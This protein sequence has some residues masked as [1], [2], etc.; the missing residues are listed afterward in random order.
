[1][2]GSQ[3]GDCPSIVIDDDRAGHHNPSAKST[4]R[5]DRDNPAEPRNRRNARRCG[6]ASSGLLPSDCLRGLDNDRDLLYIRRLAGMYRRDHAPESAVQTGGCLQTSL[7]ESR[8]DRGPDRV[9]PR[10]RPMGGPFC[11][12]VSFHDHPLLRRTDGTFWDTRRPRAGGSR[13]EKS[14]P[15]RCRSRGS[16]RYEN[17]VP[18]WLCASDE[19]P[20]RRRK[21]HSAIRKI[22]WDKMGR[23]PCFMASKPAHRS[24]TAI[25]CR[26]TA[27]S[28]L[29]EEEQVGS[30]GAAGGIESRCA[31]PGGL[32]RFSG[33]AD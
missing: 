30:P 15:G 25:P 33:R 6:R 29:R 1:M 4:R 7:V 11:H 31:C 21:I 19:R 10:H 22:R 12:A 20:P 14:F 8:P 26:R 3:P 16:S 32:E 2:A 28:S 27:D 5:P 18:C 9:G 17:P 23:A 24:T 13:G